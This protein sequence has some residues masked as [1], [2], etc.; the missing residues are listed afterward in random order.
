MKEH[1]LRKMDVEILKVTMTIYRG[2]LLLFYSIT[3]LLLFDSII[4]LLLF[5]SIISLL[6]FYSIISLLLFYS[7]ISPLLFYSIIS[8]LLFLSNKS[9]SWL[10]GAFDVFEW[11]GGL[12]HIAKFEVL[13]Q[14]TVQRIT[15][16]LRKATKLKIKNVL[17][18]P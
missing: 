16:S 15:T 6:L 17:R 9:I 14:A 5:S 1:Y 13:F 8:P 18:M 10:I 2:S 4:S 7:I 11:L 3:S 12:K